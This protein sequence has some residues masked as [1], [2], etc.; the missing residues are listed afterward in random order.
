MSNADL[1]DT[2]LIVLARAGGLV[3]LALGV[4]LLRGWR[5]RL[6]AGLQAGMVLGYT[7]AFTWLA[8]ALW[9]LHLG[10]LLKNIPILTL[11]AIAAIL[12]EER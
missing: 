7:A 9:A 10:G 11:I 6:L 4:G 3:D 12:E 8:P 1:S 5:P 2:L